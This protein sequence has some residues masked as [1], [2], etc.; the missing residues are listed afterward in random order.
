MP[1]NDEIIEA[2]LN[3]PQSMSSD[4]GSVSQHN[5]KDQIAASEHLAEQAATNKTTLPIRFAKLR[6]DGTT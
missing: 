1:T 5:L 2:N 4:V 6:P 3:K